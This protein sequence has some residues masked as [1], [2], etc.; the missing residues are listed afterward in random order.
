MF[1]KTHVC[2]GMCILK[3]LVNQ[4][5][6]FYFIYLFFW[7][8]HTACGGEG[9]GNPLQCF[10][11]KNSLDR[12]AW[13]ATVCGVARVGHDRV[14]EHTHGTRLVGSWFLDQGSSLCPLHRRMD[15]YSLYRQGSPMLRF[16][17]FYSGNI[18]VSANSCKG[19]HRTAYSKWTF[20]PSFNCSSEI[21][22]LDRGHFPNSSEKDRRE[23]LGLEV[24]RRC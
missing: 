23:K 3:N 20:Q 15:F 22:I 10:C 9:N 12:G 4:G 17:H 6:L 5:R 7:L 21:V 24:Y 13:Q 18:Y 14:T 16:F 8:H 1:L 11:L 19:H 2:V